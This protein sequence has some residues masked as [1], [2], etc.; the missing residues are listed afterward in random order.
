MDVQQSLVARFS[1]RV[2]KRIHTTYE[3][4]KQNMHL[5]SI[6]MSNNQPIE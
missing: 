6:S 2:F 5:T 3:P 4:L 1:K